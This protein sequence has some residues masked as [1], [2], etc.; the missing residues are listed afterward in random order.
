MEGPASTLPLS[1]SQAQSR[2]A[3]WLQLSKL[4]HTGAR[5]VTED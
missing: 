2:S 5:A 1:F 4:L 3:S